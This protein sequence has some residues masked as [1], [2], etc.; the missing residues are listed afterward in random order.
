[1]ITTKTEHT[2]WQQ[3]KESGYPVQFETYKAMQLMENASKAQREAALAHVQIAVKYPTKYPWMVK[4]ETE[5]GTIHEDQLARADAQDVA[6]YVHKIN[7]PKTKI[8]FIAKLD[9]SWN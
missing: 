8:H 7:G 2:A 9:N 6:D 4:Y 3:W 5:D 1:M